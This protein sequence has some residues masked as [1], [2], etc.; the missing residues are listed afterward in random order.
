[1]SW[2]IFSG[3]GSFGNVSISYDTLGNIKTYNTAN[4][5]LTYH[6]DMTRNR[7]SSVTGSGTAAKS[8]PSFTYD[9][10]GNVTNNSFRSFNYNLAEQ[11]VN[12]GGNTYVYDAQ[13]RRI[14]Q[15]D[16]KGTSYSFYSQSGTLLYRETASGGINYVY[17]NNKLIAKDGAGNTS[18][19]ELS[20]P[21]AS[22]SCSPS[23]CEVTKTG[24]GTVSITVSLNTSCT[25]GCDIEWYYAVHPLFA[26]SAGTN[27]M[28][29]SHRC[30][31]T[32]QEI[33]GVVGAI[34]TD[35]G[36][37]LKKTVN[38]SPTITCKASG[39]GGIEL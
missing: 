22:M 11:M 13:N 3:Q 38:K 30:R 39:G 36:T 17:L 37:G 10:R 32:N 9:S 16:S 23:S 28:T 20:P 6:Y 1:M 29:F 24:S 27:P 34:V 19:P 21:T 35:K 33:T 8:Y 4:S 31:G 14:K 7:L 5:S 15:T 2:L 26:N 25:K 18:K 12:S